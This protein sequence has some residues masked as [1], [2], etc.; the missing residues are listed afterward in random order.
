MLPSGKRLRNYGKIHH[1]SW[2]NSLK[3]TIFNS[4][5]YVYQRVENGYL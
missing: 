4:F 5:L 1:F 2:E 3:I